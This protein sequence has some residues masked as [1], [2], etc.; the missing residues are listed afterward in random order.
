MHEK[1]R[2]RI[3]LSAVQEKP[4]VTVP[5]LVD[6]TDSSEATIRRD[7]AALHV[8]K[9]L[10]RV[11][12]GAEAL[13]PPQFVGLAGRP[14]TVNETL[15]TRQKQAIA[16]E[17]VGLCEDGDPIIINGGT[18]TF[19]MVHFLTNRR[20]QVFTNSFNIA[21][22]LLKHSKNTIM[23]SGGTIY[24]EQNI[25]LSPFDND[26]TRNFY[27]RRMF[28]GA[29]GLGPL[30]LMEADP[31]LIQAEQKLIDQADELV[32]LVDSTK[33]RKRSSLI[34]C[35]LKRIATVITDSGIEDRDAAMLEEAGVNLIVANVQ[36][37]ARTQTAPSS[38]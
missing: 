15:N 31:L 38:A 22:H 23:L 1:E 30:G 27:A 7:I 10:R 2:H 13:H 37:D 4:V 11:R 26:V 3:I 25:V 6:L 32:V 21:E 12:G 36:T 35:G 33:F 28:M 20:M 8:Q 19:Q 9:K 34:L 18:T 29:Q 16:K 17:A 14:F 5:E 24:R